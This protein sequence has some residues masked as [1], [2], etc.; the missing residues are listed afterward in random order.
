MEIIFNESAAEFMNEAINIAKQSTCL[1]SKC[2]CIIVANN[3]IIGK[4]FNSPP[5]NL[6]SQRRCKNIKEDYNKKVTDKTCCIHAEQRA[7]FDALKNNPEKLPNSELYFI[8]IDNENNKKFSRNPY[9][10]ICSKM[11]IDL[12]IKKFILWHENG[13]TSYE[14]EE[15]NN[16]SFKYS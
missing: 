15:Y 8:R 6:E 16:K 11:A 5:N 2:G 13:I 14:T 9:C 3:E 12:G 7:M 1:R 10:T 4:G